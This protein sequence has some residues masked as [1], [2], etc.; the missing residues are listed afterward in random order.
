MTMSLDAYLV[1]I[2]DVH[3]VLSQ[4]Y[5]R[6]KKLERE[7]GFFSIEKPQTLINCYLYSLVS[8][9]SHYSTNNDVYVQ[10]Y[11]IELNTYSSNLLI[12]FYTSMLQKACQ[13]LLSKCG[14][15]IP[16]YCTYLDHTCNIDGCSSSNKFFTFLY[17]FLASWLMKIKQIKAISWVKCLH[18]VSQ[19]YIIGFMS[20]IWWQW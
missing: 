17:S 19:T 2:Y 7:N 13:L 10:K 8:F 6:C 9:I 1:D 12:T 14:Y 16:W 18:F 11:I 20:I 5:C 4:H 15:F 3:D